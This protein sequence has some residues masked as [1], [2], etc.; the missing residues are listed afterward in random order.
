MQVQYVV[1]RLKHLLADP[2]FIEG[3]VLSRVS[4]NAC[5]TRLHVFLILMCWGVGFLDRGPKPVV[6]NRNP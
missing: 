5:C 2:M 1:L 6:P 3:P 4:M